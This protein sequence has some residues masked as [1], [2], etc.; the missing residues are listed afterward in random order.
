[1]L[2]ILGISIAKYFN[3]IILPW[4][5]LAIFFVYIFYVDLFILHVQGKV[6]SICNAFSYVASVGYVNGVNNKVNEIKY[7]TEAFNDKIEDFQNNIDDLSDKID[8]LNDKYEQLEY[9][10]QEYMEHEDDEDD[11][12]D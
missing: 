4:V 3:F 7:D 1:M 12:F 10:L 11:E 2:F 8:L 9:N 6:S 5:E